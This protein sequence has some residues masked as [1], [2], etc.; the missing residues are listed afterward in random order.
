MRL[1]QVS[2]A[3]L[4]LLPALDALLE[5]GSVTG[6]ARRLHLTQSAVSR[7]LARLRLLLGDE[8]FVRSGRGLTATRRARELAGPLRRS[9]AE[10]EALLGG[11][12]AGF[13]PARA[14][15]RFSVAAIDYPQLVVLAPLA[16]RLAGVAP[17][18]E[19]DLRPVSE[20]ND[21]ELERGELD[22][23]V[24]PRQASDPRS[25]TTATCASSPPPTRRG[26]SR[27]RATPPCPTS[28]SRP[29]VGPAARSMRSWPRAA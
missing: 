7:A 25:T 21:R 20:A 2:R 1:T 28:W 15:R 12:G 27:R 4:N 5:E 13:D 29:A 6:A 19:L 23:V 8:L 24:S 22:L 11:R 3:D 26:A 18:V 17:G 9:L 16:R 10:V 14:R